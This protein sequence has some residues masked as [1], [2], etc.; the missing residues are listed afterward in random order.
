MRQL[1]IRVL[2]QRGERIADRAQNAGG[3]L[4]EEYGVKFGVLF[5]FMH[6]LTGSLVEWGF[7]YLIFVWIVFT[8]FSILVVGL[9]FPFVFPMTAPEWNIGSWSLFLKIVG[10]VGICIPA[11]WGPLFIG[12]WDRMANK[13][14]KKWSS[15]GVKEVK[16]PSPYYREGRPVWK[17]VVGTG[18]CVGARSFPSDAV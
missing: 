7:V 6:V 14:T 12:Q 18:V 11:I 1:A 3:P 4:Q 15:S 10:G 9:G 2:A 5:A 8:P 17:K 16:T 13:L